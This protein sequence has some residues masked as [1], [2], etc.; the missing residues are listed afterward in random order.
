MFAR[1]HRESAQ[2]EHVRAIGEPGRTPDCQNHR[3][4]Q[5]NR[6]E[7]VLAGMLND[8]I[9]SQ[10]LEKGPRYFLFC[11]LLRKEFNFMTDYA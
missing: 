2:P 3:N 8:A 9:P 10:S 4:I 11:N 1:S 6:T 5:K 7:H